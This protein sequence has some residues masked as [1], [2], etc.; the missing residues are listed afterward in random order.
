[1]AADREIYPGSKKPPDHESIRR[2]LDLSTT[3]EVQKT[4]Q[5]AVHIK[6]REVGTGIYLRGIVEF[7]NICDNNCY[8][9]GIRKS[10]RRIVRF[11][12]SEDEIVA[13]SLKANRQGI[14]SI[15][16]QSGERRD[17]KYLDMVERLVRRIKKESKGKIGI[18]LSLGEQDEETYHRW[19]RAGAHRYLLRI[20][21]TNK[22]LYRKI[23]PKGQSYNKRF[24]CLAALREIGYQVG[25]GVLIGIPGQTT[26]DLAGDVL[27]FREIDLDMIGMGPYIIHPQTPLAEEARDHD[28]KVQLDLGLKMIAACRIV[29]PDINIAATTALQALDPLGWR[30]GIQAGANV[31]MPDITPGKYRKD[32]FLYPGK[33]YDLGNTDPVAYLR[34]HLG[35]IS[36]NIVPFKWGDSP[37]LKK[38]NRGFN[39]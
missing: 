31:V 35:D 11:Q 25:S 7:S 33:D 10:N 26:D 4:F 6:S 34:F 15:V 2:I 21:T 17:K 28:Q 3:G 39:H 23:H 27:F 12:M 13:I 22:R 9:C 14:G 18:T 16:L 5:T 37:H 36:V 38:S 29:M 8:Y 32:Y 20:E 19:F 30:Q 1:M 24:Q